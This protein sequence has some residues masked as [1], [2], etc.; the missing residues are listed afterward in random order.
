MRVAV[1]GAGF[2]GLATARHLRDFGHDVTVFEKA[3]DVGGV[4][5][6]TRQ[7]PGVS[8]Q[9][10]KDTYCFSDFPMPSDFPEWPSGE[11]VQGYLHAYAKRF[12]LLPL[13]RLST[14]VRAAEQDGN[15]RWT[16]TVARQARPSSASDST[17]SPSATASSRPPP[18][19]ITSAR[20]SSARPG[21][22]C[23]IRRSSPG[24]RTRRASTW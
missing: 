22:P 6:R 12:G 1:I 21:A 20:P 4:W 9:N 13:T 16:L 5:S 23:A 3:P 18:R 14:Q 7:Y 8:T 2:A 15:G 24:P 19:P 11:Q 10:G 17:S